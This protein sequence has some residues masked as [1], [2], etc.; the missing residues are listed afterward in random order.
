LGGGSSD[1]A[2]CLLA[3]NR[4]WGCG[5]G[6]PALESIGLGL[7]ADVP[8]FLRG[9]NAWVEGIGE[10]ITP[11]VGDAALPPGRFLVARPASGLST[12]SIFSDPLLPRSTPSATLAGFAAHPCGRV[13]EYGHNDLQNVA[14]RICPGVQE[15]LEWLGAQGLQGRM[16]GSGS[17]VFAPTPAGFAPQPAPAGW[18]VRM[19]SNL[20]IHPL[21]GWAGQ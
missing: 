13:Y 11:L 12:P 15:A 4:L 2:T 10:A 14:V 18:Q 19:C 16:T 1:A 9:Y 8:F 7:G 5:L 21:A 6:L 17:A 20:A 3:L